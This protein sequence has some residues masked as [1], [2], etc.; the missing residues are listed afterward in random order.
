MSFDVWLPS[1]VVNTWVATPDRMTSP[2]DA[3]GPGKDHRLFQPTE[4]QR[5]LADTF[6]DALTDLLPLERLRHGLHESE[7]VWNRLG[8]I[9]LFDMGVPDDSAQPALSAA[10]EALIVLRL[11][12]Q[13]AHP[14]VLATIGAN[15]MAE[16][17][18]APDKRVAAGVREAELVVA[19]DPHASA[20]LVREADGS[21]RFY[22]AFRRGGVIDTDLWHAVMISAATDAVPV[23]AGA[24][25][26]ERMRLIDAAA[27]AGMAK[28]TLDMAV[29]YAK[30]RHQ[31]GW[32]IGAFQAVKHHCA[33]MAVAARLAAD[34]VTF[35]AVAVD[36]NRDDVERQIEA[37]L[38]AAAEAA[39][40][41]AALNIQIHGGLGFSEEADPHL[42]LKRVRLQIS[43]SGGVARA[44]SRLD[45]PMRQ[46]PWI[47]RA[48]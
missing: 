39:L 47:T 45:A 34:Q 14:S 40:H 26:A 17:D 23:Q 10:E 9:G 41:N 2:Q 20:V 31:F 6:G 13:L 3:A 19:D 8:E 5:E 46:P 4:S 25:A 15:H 12:E 21:L 22:P 1:N 27:L 42:F 48:A 30:L 32:P 36:H 33:N 7:E 37:A 28:G 43:L 35:A 18:G 29:A 38:I 44:V 24:K 11:G 16:H